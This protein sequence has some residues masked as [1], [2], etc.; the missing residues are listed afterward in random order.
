M[1]LLVRDTAGVRTFAMYNAG[2]LITGRT[3]S[4]SLSKNGGA[5]SAAAGAVAEIG[6]GLYKITYTTADTNTYGDLVFL[7]TASGADPTVFTDAVSLFN[8][9]A[10]NLGAAALPTIGFGGAGGLIGTW[11]GSPD[12]LLEVDA[13]GYV[14]VG[15]MGDK[16][17]YTLHL[18]NSGGVA[19]IA[20]AVWNSIAGSYVGAG[21]LG[22]KLND[23]VADQW[24][25][26]LPG[27]YGSGK[28]GQIL[29]LNLDAAV[30][31]LSTLDS[32]D[33]SVAVA[34][35]LDA[36]NTELSAVPTTTGSLRSMLQFLFTYFRNRRTITSSLETLYKENAST[37]LGTSSISDNGTTFDK[38]EMS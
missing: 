8:G 37:S 4:V 36:S 14:T 20:A 6:S 25:V 21:T 3:V 28:A 13:T 18:T 12:H 9:T 29:G 17:G 30:S 2:V 10:T 27:A 19:T 1:A 38:G 5:F 31:S 16:T 33:V 15:T 26:A 11:S 32:T 22:K 35:V 23:I 24:D 7:C 34:A